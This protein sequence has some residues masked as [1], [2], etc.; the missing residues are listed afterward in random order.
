[1][2]WNLKDLVRHAVTTAFNPREGAALVLAQNIPRELGW[3]LMSLVSVLSVIAVKGVELL[4]R[5]FGVTLVL[6]P[7]EGAFA[8]AIVQFSLAVIMVFGI[9]WGGRAF[10]GQGRFGDT[11]VLVAW[12]QF[13][14]FCLQILQI[15]AL[16][17]FPV[18]VTVI[19]MAGIVLFFWLLTTF[20]AVIHG[21]QNMG[22]VFLG[23]IGAL[24]LM[25]FVMTIILTMIGFQIPEV[26]SDV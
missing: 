13:V 5:G 12:L 9:F 19:S 22:R 3:P 10:G 16:F 17:L 21:F 1:M 8:L 20:V 15:A 26:P 4:F 25:A 14:L 6:S 11:I 23:I 24:V 7:V 2:T 18:L